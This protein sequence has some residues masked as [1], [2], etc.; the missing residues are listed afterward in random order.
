ME[1]IN[2]QKLRAELKQT[3]RFNDQSPVDYES[4]LLMQYRSNKQVYI[5]A[6]MV[7]NS[8]LYN[9]HKKID[10]TQ[11]VLM[12]VFTHLS[13][14]KPYNLLHVVQEIID[15]CNNYESVTGCISYNNKICKI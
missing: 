2:I 5:G 12:T 7:D 8:L 6:T 3:D 15:A 4:N 1:V 9:V 14:S 10:G 13:K 11:Y